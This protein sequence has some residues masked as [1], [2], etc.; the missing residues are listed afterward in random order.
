MVLFCFFLLVNL[1]DAQFG[2][3][4]RGCPVTGLVPCG[5]PE[6]PCTLCDFFRM[7]ERIIDFVLFKIVPAL[8]VLMIAIGGFMYIVAYVGLAE[9]GPEM[10]S[11]AKSLFKSVIIGL[12]IAY[13][14]WLIINTFFWAIGVAD[15]TGLEHGWW[16]INCN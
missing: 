5:G 4:R 13:G 7:I 15:W 2:E 1:A 12:L 14:A 10:L 6:C 11:R 3:G 9:G 16:Q 8:A